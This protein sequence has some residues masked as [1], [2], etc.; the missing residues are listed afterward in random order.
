MLTDVVYVFLLL[1]LGSLPKLKSC[2]EINPRVTWMTNQPNGYWSPDNNWVSL[3]CERP[4]MTSQWVTSCLTNTS[5]WSFGDSNGVRLY[6]I[7]SAKIFPNDSSHSEWPSRLVKSDNSNRITL[8]FTPPEYPLYMGSK[9]KPR[10]RYGGVA[11]QIDSIPSTGKHIVTIHYYL[12]TAYY[13]LSVVVTRLTAL[14]DAIQ[15]LLKRNPNILV[16]IRG[17]HVFYVDP[18]LNHAIGGDNLGIYLLKMIQDIFDDLKD[19]VVFL[20]GWDMTLSSENHKYHPNDNIP[21]EMIKTLLA[22][23][24]A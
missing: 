15:R 23:K 20:D 1:V 14:H 17:P 16:G 10:I 8:T 7:I 22:F 2:S 3:L 24:C 11:K 9:W 4:N 13:H 6:N 21:A 18:N 12:H 5:V 19:K